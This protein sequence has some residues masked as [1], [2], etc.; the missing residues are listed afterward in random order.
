MKP[1]QMKKN[2]A[3]Q[4]ARSKNIG[5][6]VF[7]AFGSADF[8][9]LM[10]HRGP[11]A[12]HGFP[13]PILSCFDHLG[14]RCW[15][16]FFNVKIKNFFRIDDLITDGFPN[17]QPVEFFLRPCFH[18]LHLGRETSLRGWP[19]TMD[20]PLK[21]KACFASIVFAFKAVFGRSSILYGALY[22]FLDNSF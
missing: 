5:C 10:G 18:D 13:G 15:V 6:R 3:I 1:K 16:E 20:P 21:T 9:V 19:I 4:W 14:D 8:L 17:Q 2:R 7:P 11:G 12:I 22:P